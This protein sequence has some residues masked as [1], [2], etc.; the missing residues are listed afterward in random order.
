MSLI[1]FGGAFNPPHLGHIHM[2][3]AALRETSDA[4]LIFMPTYAPPHREI[5]NGPDYETRMLMTKI[6]TGT[7]TIAEIEP[8]LH[9]FTEEERKKRIAAY[10][11][12]QKSLPCKKWEVANLEKTL[13]EKTNE[14]SFTIRTVEALQKIYPNKKIYVLIGADQ[15]K[16]LNTWKSIDRLASMVVFLVAVRN[17]VLP[18][19]P[20]RH[21]FLEWDGETVSSTVIREKIRNG[22]SLKG[23]V[24]PPLERLLSAGKLRNIYL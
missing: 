21:N 18:D 24:A 9:A 16:K 12:Y 10:K 19:C 4:K 7:A 11:I 17:G 8:L 3:R 20:Y 14:P 13:Y 15:A 1:L 22:S 6:S 23:L 5:L 2:A